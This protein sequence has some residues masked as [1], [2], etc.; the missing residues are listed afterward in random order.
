ML[1]CQSIDCLP[2][3]MMRMVA[4]YLLPSELWKLCLACN[5][6]YNLG[7]EDDQMWKLLC[8][9]NSFD[10][11]SYLVRKHDALSD[12][13]AWKSIARTIEGI[14]RLDSVH[15]IGGLY[16]DEHCLVSPQEAHS[17]CLLDSTFAVIIGG[18]GSE[19]EVD[20]IDAT[21]LPHIERLTCHAMAPETMRFTYG[22]STVKL[23]E[24][25]V[26]RYG[27]VSQGGYR[28]AVRGK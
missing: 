5:R 4:H 8:S 22:F 2:Q 10:G 9:L 23:D 12:P 17:A 27:G 6:L 1:Q 24:R 19:Q 21:Y 11:M 3:D 13:Y 26:I 28:V 25:S 18:W 16:E 20:I 7:R 14:R 15:W